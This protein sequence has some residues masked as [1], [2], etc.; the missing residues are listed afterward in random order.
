MNRKIKAMMIDKGV[1]Q[2]DIAKQLDI[3]KGTVSGAIGGFHKSEAV[4]L[5]LAELLGVSYQKL[6]SMYKRRPKKAA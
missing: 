6:E 4:M 5:R 1:K 3:T 2:V